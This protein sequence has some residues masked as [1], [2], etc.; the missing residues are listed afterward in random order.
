MTLELNWIANP[1]PACFHVVDLL[2]RD[3]PIQDT[4]LA[5]ALDAGTQALA[6][7]I[8]NNGFSREL[9]LSHL[10]PLSANI[11]GNR[12][13]ASI[14]LT[15]IVGP[16]R[17]EQR[18]DRLTD[19]LTHLESAFSRAMPDLVE[20][21]E[22][23]AAPLRRDW[24]IHGETLM[25]SLRRMIDEN[26][27]VSRADAILVPPAQPGGGAAHLLY[28]SVRI[29][30]LPLESQQVVPEV[31]RL[32]WLLAQ[33]NADLPMYQGDVHRDRLPYVASLAM[34]PAV[35][36]AAAELDLI[37]GR[38]GAVA[39]VINEWNIEPARQSQLTD[40]LT[41]WWETWQSQRPG[42]SIALA[43]LDRLLA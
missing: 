26:V 22:R 31:V 1:S 7:E 15:K 21:L 20:R 32:T 19:I 3:Q 23:D 16:Q 42:W 11:G 28:N 17:T 40:I 4:T 25:Q 30:V 43:A 36:T 39:T 10:V 27:V 9:F 29:E 5:G 33:L 41:R 6:R 2:L 12:Q 35:A 37:K 13:L 18:I 38:D 14:A 34:L 8:D 24:D